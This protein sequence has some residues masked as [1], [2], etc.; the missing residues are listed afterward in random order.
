MYP[1]ILVI[2][3]S[4]ENFMGSET[5][6]TL[7]ILTQHSCPPEHHVQVNAMLSDGANSSSSPSVVE[8]HPIADFGDVKPDLA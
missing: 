5:I 3:I 6:R 4:M 8:L 7:H 2:A 1:T